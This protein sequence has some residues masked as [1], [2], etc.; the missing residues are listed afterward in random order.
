MNFF[1]FIRTS[2]W[3]ALL[4]A[5]EEDA[6]ARRTVISA[7]SISYPSS[8][9]VC[10]AAA[11]NCGSLAS[12]GKAKCRRITSSPELI[13]TTHFDFAASHDTSAPSARM[14]TSNRAHSRPNTPPAPRQSNISPGS[15]HVAANV[16][17]TADDPPPSTPFRCSPLPEHQ[18]SHAVA[19][20]SPGIPII[21]GRFHT[22]GSARSNE[23]HL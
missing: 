9:T 19:S 18:Q 8:R 7:A 15:P 14:L 22:E 20:D 4:P 10:S 1:T 6:Y 23:Y 12:F 21:Y 17:L 2:W 16:G 11:R 5:V 13:R 3:F